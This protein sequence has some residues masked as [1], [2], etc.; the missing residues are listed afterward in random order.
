MDVNE[1][2][3][4]VKAGFAATNDLFKR[5]D[6][7]GD[8]SWMV[9][10]RSIQCKRAWGLRQQL[11]DIGNLIGQKVGADET[12]TI[13]MIALGICDAAV[14]SALLHE[15]EITQT[16]L[17]WFMEYQERARRKINH[18]RAGGDPNEFRIREPFTRKSGSRMVTQRGAAFSDIVETLTQRHNDENSQEGEAPRKV[19]EAELKAASVLMERWFEE[20]AIDALEGRA[21]PA[22][23]LV[24]AIMGLYPEA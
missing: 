11:I 5:D 1:Q 24:R 21:T 12:V 2:S 8:F 17:D 13:P 20:A 19:D 10:G 7:R 16:Q 22:T 23:R 9:E 14:A 3:D 18:L 6:E 15:R 4:P